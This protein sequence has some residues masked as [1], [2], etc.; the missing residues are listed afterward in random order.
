VSADPPG[1]RVTLMCQDCAVHSRVFLAGRNG[2]G[3]DT[4]L[5]AM[6]FGWDH[7]HAGHSQ[8]VVASPATAA[9]V[10]RS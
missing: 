1:Y 2:D 7:F 8:V 3:P 9:E 10:G 6:S 4:A 5:A